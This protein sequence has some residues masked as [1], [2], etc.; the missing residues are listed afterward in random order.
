MHYSILSI[1]GLSL[2]VAS[3]KRTNESVNH[4][5]ADGTIQKTMDERAL[6]IHL[7][8]LAAVVAKVKPYQPFTFASSVDFER[9]AV[10][11]FP[12]DV[13]RQLIAASGE[14]SW[15]VS[16]ADVLVPKRRQMETMADGS[17][18]FAGL[19]SRVRG[20]S[21]DAYMVESIEETSPVAVKVQWVKYCGPLAAHGGSVEMVFEDGKWIAKEVKSEWVS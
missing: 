16:P 10:V 15:Y 21:L 2:A 5:N 1:V 7:A 14:A 11:G 18:R 20:E 19:T 9:R 6:A 4:T 3:C 12:A 17:P 13:E 8:A